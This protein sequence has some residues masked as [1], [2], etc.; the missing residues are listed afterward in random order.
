LP[1]DVPAHLREEIRLQV[2][3]ITPLMQVKGYAAPETKAVAERARLLIERSEA[4]GEH[5][6][7]PLLLFSVLYGFWAANYV[8]FNGVALLELATQFLALAEKQ[9]A[10]FPHIVG[11]RLLGTSLTCRGLRKGER[12]S[13]GRSYF[14][15]LANIVR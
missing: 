12:I 15:I 6:E 9:G 10:T 11:H 5:A 2:A 7:D 4:L 1:D 14:M 13:I 3:L 8:M